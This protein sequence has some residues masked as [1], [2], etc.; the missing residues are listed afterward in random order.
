M[1]QYQREL[2]EAL[3]LQQSL[4]MII[5][6]LTAILI[7]VIVRNWY[8]LYKKRSF[9]KKLKQSE[10][11]LN[12]KDEE[13]QRQNLIIKDNEGFKIENRTFRVNLEKLRIKF[14]EQE[15]NFN[16]TLL[17]K[18]EELERR[19]RKLEYQR[20][21]YEKSAGFK[22]VEINN[23]RLS[24]HFLK[25]VISHIYGDLEAE[26]PKQLNVFGLYIG[27]KEVQNQIIPIIALRNIFKLLDYTV[28]VIKHDFVIIDQEVE[29]IKVFIDVI[30][31]FKPDTK[32]K[33]KNNLKPKN[34][35]S[36]KI[37]PT[38]F[39]PFLE[40]AL[41]HGSLNKEESALIIEIQHEEPSSIIYS[42]EN[43]C[44]PLTSKK[45][46]E[47]SQSSFGLL[48]LKNLLDVYYPQN[49]LQCG[50]LSESRYLSKLEIHLD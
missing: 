29:N 22:N 42:V 5:L 8:N 10:Q 23:T 40:N 45:L 26:R 49:K 6:I 3:E 43:T 35:E 38:L 37:K 4:V 41:K 44:E 20:N 47:K 13:L 16:K 46:E 18:A 15:K 31:Y 19:E 39:F 50:L 27:S 1:Y 32:I 48:A 33:F 25:N 7:L 24:A 9:R 14:D 28:A 12:N 17:E 11:N 36:L 30:K 34:K 2:Q 21:A